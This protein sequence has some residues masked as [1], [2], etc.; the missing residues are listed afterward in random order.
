MCAVQVDEISRV[1]RTGLDVDEAEAEIE[2]VEPVRAG[3][4]AAAV[5]EEIAVEETTTTVR[6]SRRA[7]VEA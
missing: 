2:V 5:V 7:A 6:R 1:G 4:R 3:G